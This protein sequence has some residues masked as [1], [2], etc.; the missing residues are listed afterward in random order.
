MTSNQWVPASSKGGGGGASL[1]VTDGSTSVNP[2]TELAFTAG[3]TVT[4]GGGGVAQVAIAGGAPLTVTATGGTEPVPPLGP[5][6]PMQVGGVLS[7]TLLAIGTLE[8]PGD[9][10]TL[11]LPN[12]GLISSTYSFQPVLPDL[13]SWSMAA[14]VAVFGSFEPVANAL[15]AVDLSALAQVGTNDNSGTLQPQFN[16]L[17]TLDLS[18]LVIV[19]GVNAGGDFGGQFAA[20]TTVDLSALVTVGGDFDP[21][22]P[23]LAALALPSAVFIHAFEPSVDSVTT[24]DL[25]ALTTIGYTIEPASAGLTTLGLPA[26][27]TV[28][29]GGVQLSSCPALA[30]FTIYS[31]LLSVGGDFIASG[32]AL[33]QAS[34]DGILEALAALDGTGGTT[35][36]DGHTVDLSGGTSATPGVGGAAGVVTLTGR[37]NT[38]NTN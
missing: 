19:G 25:P 10:V 16:S 6:S 31:G 18:A 9:A 36:Y 37:G 2:A 24:I 28:G 7:A 29:G 34:V 15:T 26:L 8:L 27:L 5:I 23:A 12:L 21:Y 4:D 3:A 1:N 14:L 32:I 35:S 17:T 20:L 11:D 13:T 38:V 33:T 22:M 30:D